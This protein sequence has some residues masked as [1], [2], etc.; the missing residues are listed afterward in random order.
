VPQFGP[1]KR[2]NLVSNFRELGFT[3]PY[4]SGGR[5]PHQEYMER[6]TVKVPL[7]N[8]HEGDLSVGLLRKILREAQITNEE[9]TNLR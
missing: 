3:G 9:W 6:G 5:G 7:P 4:Q 8:S 1:I 2:R